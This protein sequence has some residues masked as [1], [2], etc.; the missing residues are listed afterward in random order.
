MAGNPGRKK[1]KKNAKHGRNKLK[2]AAYA[3]S[4][5]HEK[6]KKRALLRHLKKHPSDAQAK[7]AVMAL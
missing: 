4:R 7:S 3:N 2:C 6:N 5:R 1:G